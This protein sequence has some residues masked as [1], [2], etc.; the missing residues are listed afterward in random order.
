MANV[1]STLDA[2]R[3]LSRALFRSVRP[4]VHRLWT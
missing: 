4:D 2:R 3:W 1:F